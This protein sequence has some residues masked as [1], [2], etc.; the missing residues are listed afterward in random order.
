MLGL[1]RLELV[2]GGQAQLFLRHLVVD[3][4]HVGVG[5]REV[6][7]I[8]VD[9]LGPVFRQFFGERGVDVPGYQGALGDQ[10]RRRIP[11]GNRLEDLLRGGLHVRGEIAV[12]RIF[13]ENLR[14]A[15]RGNAVT[16]RETDVHGLL[17]VGAALGI[18]HISLLGSDV[19]Y[20]E[21][22]PGREHRQTF[23]FD[24]RDG[25][26]SCDD[27]AAP[28][29]H[30][31]KRPDDEDEQRGKSNCGVF[32]D[33][34]DV[35]FVY[36]VDHCTSLVISVLSILGE[37]QPHFAPL[38]GRRAAVRGCHRPVTSRCQL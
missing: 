21:F 22:P 37:T 4:A 5:E 34:P 38:C 10:I 31:I 28:G 2:L 35:R 1:H 23:P 6:A 30:G 25:A 33:L 36:F 14:Y 12:M 7:H 11:G 17:V 8:D 20:G 19:E 15:V 27:A 18:F 16:D 3:G 32:D 9:D 24:S 26:E 29:R 13:L